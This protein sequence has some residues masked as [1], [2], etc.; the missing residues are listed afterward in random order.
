MNKAARIPVDD[1]VLDDANPRIKHFLE[2]YTVLND[3][4]MLLALGAG[5]EEEGDSTSMGSYARL[6]NSIRASRGIIQSIIVRELYT[7]RSKSDMPTQDEA[8]K[9]PLAEDMLQAIL[10]RLTP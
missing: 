4:S 1:I 5:A 9:F 2:M 8:V 6:K 7:R 10:A 3:D